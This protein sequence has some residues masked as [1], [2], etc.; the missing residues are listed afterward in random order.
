MRFYWKIPDIPLPPVTKSEAMTDTKV[1]STNYVHVSEM[2][3]YHYR[4]I[5]IQRYTV[6][7]QYIQDNT[8]S[9]WRQDLS[10]GQLLLICYI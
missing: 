6:L 1:C 7:Y 2:F 4:Y 9:L 3:V 10:S 8:I 5:I